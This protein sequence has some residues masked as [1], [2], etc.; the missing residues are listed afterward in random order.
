MI[1]RLLQKNVQ[2]FIEQHA[3][4]DE[5][6]LLLR[7]K[8]I[9]DIQASVIAWQISGRRK[10]KTRFVELYRC[11][12]STPLVENDDTEEKTNLSGRLPYC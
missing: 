5:Q 2:E 7:H 8:T 10:A 9:L 4:D 12:N 11:H 3:Q 1:D 6:Q